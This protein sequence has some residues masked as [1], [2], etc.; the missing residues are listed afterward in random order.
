MPS[1]N[2]LF[3][4]KPSALSSMEL[5]DEDERSPLSE[6]V[7]AASPPRNIMAIARLLL[8]AAR[9]SFSSFFSSELNFASPEAVLEAVLDPVFD[10]VLEAVLDPVF[11]AV[12]D[13]V[14][15][16]GLDAVFLAA[17][18]AAAFSNEA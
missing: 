4:K 16:A 10:A 7:D 17:V 13:A 2:S 18:P 1:V 8:S 3:P 6:T 14:F 15:G 11:D 12:L 5:I 9:Y